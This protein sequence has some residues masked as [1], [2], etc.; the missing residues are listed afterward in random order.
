[1][2]LVT[3]GGLLGSEVVR[4]LQREHDVTGTYHSKPKDGAIRLDV[5]DRENTLRS[6]TALQPE[7][8]VHTAAQ[9]NVDYCEDHRKEA[10]AANAYG[11]K[12]IVDAARMAGSKVIY[13][14]TDFVFDGMKGMYVEDD[15]VDPL[16]FYAYSKLIGEYY[17]KGIPGHV[18]ARTSVVYGNARQN[19]VSWVKDSLEN[20]QKIRVVTNQYNSPTLSVDCAEAIAALIKNDAAGIFHTAGSERISRY[21]F[22][23]KIARFYG[24][25]DA[26]IEPVT[27]DSLRQK[28][29]RPMDSSLDVHKVGAYHKMLDI[30][31]GLQ[32]MEKTR[33][34]G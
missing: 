26:G 5:S 2:I 33:V 8:I 24:L 18:I 9:T 1:M 19:F 23:K 25:D 27:S 31:G 7:I 16:S 13:V 30:M 10:M 4:A 29:K 28:A 14:S 11:T 6:I 21:E 12:N 22:A 3:G 17:V 20:G 34:T 32:K 15:P